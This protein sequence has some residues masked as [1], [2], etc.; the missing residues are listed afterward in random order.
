MIQE[1]PNQPTGTF[2]Q[3]QSVI[4]LQELKG[5]YGYIHPVDGT[6][7]KINPKTLLLQVKKRDGRLTTVSVKPE[8]VRPAD[9]P[10]HDDTSTPISDPAATPSPFEDDPTE[11]G[12]ASTKAPKKKA[13]MK[14]LQQHITELE[15]KLE[16]ARPEQVERAYESCRNAQLRIRDLE[17]FRRED[18]STIIRLKKR[19]QELEQATSTQ[20]APS[21]DTNQQD[22]TTLEAEIERLRSVNKDLTL[23]NVTHGQEKHCLR[24]Q[25][26][27]AEKTIARLQSQI[28]HLQAEPKQPD[29]TNP[30]APTNEVTNQLR[31]AQQH[32]QDQQDEI[33]TLKG[34]NTNLR[35]EK[36]EL[37]EQL[38]ELED[39]KDKENKTHY[40]ETINETT[41][42]KSQGM[43]RDNVR[44]TSS[45]TKSHENH[46]EATART[47]GLQEASQEQQ[48]THR[49][50][51]AIDSEPAAP[52]NSIPR[53]D[54]DNGRDNIPPEN[55][56]FT[57]TRRPI[58]V[59][60]ATA[61][62][63]TFAL[64]HASKLEEVNSQLLDDK[65]YCQERIDT[66]RE[67]EERIRRLLANKK[68]KAPHKLVLIHLENEN[69]KLRP[70]PT[71]PIEIDMATVG[72]AVGMERKTV[73]VKIQ[74][75]SQWGALTKTKQEKPLNKPGAL[76][77]D[78]VSVALNPIVF[79]EPEAIAPRKDGAE[80]SINHGGKREHCKKCGSTNLKPI[81]HTICL[82]CGREYINHS[83]EE[84]LQDALW[85]AAPEIDP[86]TRPPES[87]VNSPR[88]DD[89]AKSSESQ[90]DSP[91]GTIYVDPIEHY[92]DSKLPYKDWCHMTVIGNIQTLHDMAGKIGLK[93]QWFQ[94]HPTF[95]HYDLTPGKRAKAIAYGAI[96]ISREEYADKLIAR[97]PSLK[98]YAN[99]EST[100]ELASDITIT[101]EEE[102]AP[103]SQVDSP[104]EQTEKCKCCPDERPAK[105][106][107]ICWQC[108]KKIWYWNHTS[109]SWRCE[110]CNTEPAPLT[111]AT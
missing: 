95:P 10:A 99:T 13:S 34:E 6:I 32:I 35:E 43:R 44:G 50:A 76:N 48:T 80:Y 72:S 62:L 28:K 59:A 30:Q 81:H 22:T 94:R 71:D 51:G 79:Q 41:N 20:P 33:A 18:E 21:E 5:G 70:D 24:E 9:P 61:T 58:T 8:H 74:E 3:G 11:P 85:I 7:L 55:P 102:S 37:E 107:G 111:Q 27:Q 83:E 26:Q 63:L 103:E 98:Q 86:A 75:L 16:L 23:H 60:S 109:K 53:A 29:L 64:Q 101:A 56:P 47:S 88:E 46:R 2:S 97:I 67:R 17:Y 57:R 1:H 104:R 93:R 38:A 14:E 87:Q 84:H 106:S 31:L 100:E 12:S 42:Q 77:Y 40:E 15:I 105:P 73:G 69:S 36:A 4:W 110:W 91:T 96:P 52:D 108:Q 39:N 68:I 49:Q 65:K 66:Y 92:E 78:K 89:Q 90:V 45:L 82:D 19:I 25:L 54:N